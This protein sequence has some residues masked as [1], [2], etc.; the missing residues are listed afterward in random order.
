MIRV[1]ALF[2][3]VLCS[4]CGVLRPGISGSGV[5][6]SEFRQVPAFEEVNLS[7]FGTVNVNVGHAPSVCVT[8]DDNL[9]SHVDTFV[10]NGKLI[11]KP[12]HRIRPTTGLNIDVTVPQ[13]TAAR[14]SGAGDMNVIDV[15]GDQLD[16]SI[17]G[18]GTLTA[19]GYVNQISTSISGAGDADL[20]E[21]YAEQASVKIAG[22]GDVSVYA[23]ES[24]SVRVA[25]AGDVTFMGTPST[26]TNG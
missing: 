14:I 20:K 23:S 16:L 3:L 4:G 24:I 21:L 12:R 26:L 8:T 6:H 7:G 19:N 17:S 1:P 13:L 22:A 2:L 25:G 5:C 10:E 11:I 15:A 9:V 18:A